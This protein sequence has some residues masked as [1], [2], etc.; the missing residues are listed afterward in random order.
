MGAFTDDGVRIASTSGSHKYGVLRV[1]DV[2]SGRELE[3]LPVGDRAVV[4]C[5]FSADGRLLY[6]VADGGSAHLWVVSSP[7]DRRGAT[8]AAIC[9]ETARRVAVEERG[10][11]GAFPHQVKSCALSPDGATLATAGGDQTV[12]LW[13]VA[14]GRERCHWEG[15]A[16]M[17]ACAWRPHD[18]LLVVG[19]ELGT[20]HWL[21]ALNVWG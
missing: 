13:E 21:R 16:P 5:D 2:A 12:R 11:F 10:T 15:D 7:W 9:A 14:T 1:W 6:G 19:D 8:R 3:R 20:L 17:T 18:N 4:S